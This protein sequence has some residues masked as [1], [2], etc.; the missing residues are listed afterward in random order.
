MQE[1][2]ELL[3]SLLVS[4]FT[5]QCSICAHVYVHVQRENPGQHERL[6][7]AHILSANVFNYLGGMLVCCNF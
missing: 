6:Q 7:R 5:E 1:L 2:Y 4:V 3:S